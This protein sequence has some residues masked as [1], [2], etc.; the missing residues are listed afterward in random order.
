MRDKIFT[1]N[2][3]NGYTLLFSIIVASVVLSIAAFILSVSRKQ[4]IL[5]SV[6]RDS[7]RAIYAADSAMQ[8]AIGAFWNGQLDI[9]NGATVYCNGYDTT[10]TFVEADNVD[11][12]YGIRI[13]GD[14]GNG[15]PYKVYEITTPLSFGFNNDTCAF[16]TMIRGFDTGPLANQKIVIESRGY[17]DQFS[18]PCTAGKNNPRTVERAVRVIILE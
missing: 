2:K 7:T 8:C 11:P 12:L 16:V 18:A 10:G 9:L 4:F 5:S 13:G 3:Q 14:D 1:I 15:Q 17:N 6:S